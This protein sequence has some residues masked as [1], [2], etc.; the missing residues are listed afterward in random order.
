MPSFSVVAHG[1][2][3]NFLV[4]CVFIQ[5]NKV[6]YFHYDV[7]LKEIVVVVYIRPHIRIFIK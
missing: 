3:V 2:D 6:Y 4:Q 5:F 7:V 1:R